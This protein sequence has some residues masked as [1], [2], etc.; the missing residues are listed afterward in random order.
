MPFTDTI[1]LEAK[2]RANFRCVVCQQP[3]VEV[4]H[5]H[6]EGQGG[7]NT[8]DNAA[9]LCGSCHTQYGGNPDLRKQLREMRDWWWKRCAEARHI[10]VDAGVARK[11]DELHVAVLQGQKRHDEVL[12][13]AKSI[14]AQQLS[15]AQQQVLSS[16]TLAGVLAVTSGLATGLPPVPFIQPQMSQPIP[17]PRVQP[18]AYWVDP[19][20]P[21]PEEKKQPT[22]SE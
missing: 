22:Q 10:T 20:L 6:P 12:S 21:P 9:P 19:I 17:L 2:Q 1:R 7:P 3:W 18:Q 15:L 13:E 4:H 8:L 5:I 16:G 14:V 11:L